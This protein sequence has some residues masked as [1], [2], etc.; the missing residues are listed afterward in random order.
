MR[1]CSRADAGR[2][3][4]EAAMPAPM[5]GC[6]NRNGAATLQMPTASAGPI[7]GCLTQAAPKKD[8]NTAAK[9]QVHHRG[10]TDPD[11]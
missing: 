4:R 10:R 1:L 3:M 7:V 5:A 8:T 2:G 9:P 11:E 6:I